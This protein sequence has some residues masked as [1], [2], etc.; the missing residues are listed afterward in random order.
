MNNSKRRRL[1][2]EARHVR[3]ESGRPN[4]MGNREFRRSDQGK[5][6][7]AQYL[8]KLGQDTT[9]LVLPEVAA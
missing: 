5:A 4:P 6:Q 2:K 3:G 7:I 1:A 9:A 8:A